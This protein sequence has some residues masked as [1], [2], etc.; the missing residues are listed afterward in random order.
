MPLQNGHSTVYLSIANWTNRN[1]HFAE[2]LDM[3]FWT[4]LLINIANYTRNKGMLS[5]FKHLDVAMKNHIQ[6]SGVTSYA[7]Y[8]SA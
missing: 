5:S 8:A 4:G 2:V 1:A 6:L 3:H 7:C